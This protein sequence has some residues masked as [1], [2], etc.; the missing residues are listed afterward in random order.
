MDLKTATA[1][2]FLAGLLTGCSSAPPPKA[3][4]VAV[5]GTVTLPSGQPVKGVTLMMFPVTANQGQEQAKLGADGKFNVKLIPGKYTFAFEGPAA[6]LKAVPA[7]YHQNEA[8]HSFEVPSGGGPV[9][10]KL[11]N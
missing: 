9:E 2:L 11:A 5:S 4:P 1:L 10:L 7:K 8:A 6:E 3:D